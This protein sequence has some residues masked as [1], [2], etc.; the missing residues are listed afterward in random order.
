MTPLDK[1]GL[2]ILNCVIIVVMYVILALIKVMVLIG[3]C[4]CSDGAVLVATVLF[5]WR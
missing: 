4:S 2:E 1:C 5:L 3:M